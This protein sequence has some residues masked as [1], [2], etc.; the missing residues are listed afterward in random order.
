MK[1]TIPASSSQ[2]SSVMS[3]E[4]TRRIDVLSVIRNFVP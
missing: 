2:S 1:M 3:A 4:P